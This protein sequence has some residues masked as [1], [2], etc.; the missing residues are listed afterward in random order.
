MFV[1]LAGN[2]MALLIEMVVDLGMN[3]ARTVPQN[4][5]GQLLGYAK[6][7]SRLL[8]PHDHVDRGDPHALGRRDLDLRQFVV[9]DV[10]QFVRVLEIEVEVRPGLGVVPDL[11]VV[12]RDLA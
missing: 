7:A 9:R 3:G 12:E 6:R 8:Q 10:G 11:G 4:L 5:Q 1:D 2:E